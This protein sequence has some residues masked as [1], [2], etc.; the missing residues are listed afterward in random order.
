MI[1]D[2]PFDFWYCKAP[3]GCEDPERW[4]EQEILRAMA[5]APLDVEKARDYFGFTG[6]SMMMLCGEVKQLLKKISV[7]KQDPTPKQVWTWMTNEINWGMT[8]TPSEKVV[9]T[10]LSNWECLARNPPVKAIIDEALTHFG[11]DN[12]FDVPTHVNALL[13]L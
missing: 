6:K 4:E 10:H 5:Q 3:D 8:R 9:R 12:S 2:W 7:G 1:C 13:H 11:R